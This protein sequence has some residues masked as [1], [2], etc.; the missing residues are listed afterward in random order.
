MLLN[1]ASYNAGTAMN[2]ASLV[3]FRKKDNVETSQSLLLH[4]VCPSPAQKMGIASY[5][6]NMIN[7]SQHLLVRGKLAEARA[8]AL[9]ALR[10]GD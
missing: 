8:F 3:A 1:N 9:Q 10:L 2:V 6:A 7:Y 5:H 4:Q